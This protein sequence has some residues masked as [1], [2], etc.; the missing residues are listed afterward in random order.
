MRLITW[1]S[2]LRG[3]NTPSGGDKWH[4][5]G[6]ANSPWFRIAVFTSII[7]T[8]EQKNSIFLRLDSKTKI[9]RIKHYTGNTICQKDAENENNQAVAGLIATVI[10]I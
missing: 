2:V 9:K 1:Q 5:S 3:S 6:T 10:H 4:K 7:E 8:A